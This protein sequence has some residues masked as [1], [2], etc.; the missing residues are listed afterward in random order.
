M[1]L[2]G[3]NGPCIASGPY[4]CRCTDACRMFRCPSGGSSGTPVDHV[5]TLFRSGQRCSDGYTGAFSLNHRTFRCLGLAG[6]L[7]LFSL[8]SSADP[9][10]QSHSLFFF[11]LAKPPPYIRARTPLR[12]RHS[13]AAP[14][15][16]HARRSCSTTPPRH[17][18]RQRRAPAAPAPAP[19][20]CRPAPPAPR[21]AAF[22][23]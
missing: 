2:R 21:A 5:S 9:T 1:L 7:V 23:D 10:R 19:L 3:V 16:P 17:A 18:P 20:L 4:S 14:P 12:R 6:P 11:L 15:L 8:N 13:R 22:H